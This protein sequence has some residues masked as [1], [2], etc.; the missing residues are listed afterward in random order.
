MVSICVTQF[1]FLLWPNNIPL[2]G[3]TPL[4]LCIHQVMGICVVSTL[5]P[6]IDNV[7]LDTCVQVFLWMYSFHPVGF[8]LF[9]QPCPEYLT[10]TWLI[11][12]YHSVL[13][14]G[15]FVFSLR[16]FPRLLLLPHKLPLLWS[17]IAHTYP[18]C[19]LFLWHCHDWFHPIFL[20]LASEPLKG[21]NCITGCLTP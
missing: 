6:L 13:N 7:A 12:W 16:T 3:D 20:L 10:L 15:L 19:R 18:D 11:H 8:V 17:L 4:C 2:Y 14:R 1:L 9:F 5:G 21:K